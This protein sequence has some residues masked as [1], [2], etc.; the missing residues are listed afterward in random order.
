MLPMKSLIR[1]YMFFCVLMLAEAC[2][3]PTGTFV[4]LEEDDTNINFVN[5]VEESD[6]INIF[7]FENIYNGGGVGVGDFKTCISPA[8]WFPINYT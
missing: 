2:S 5:A 1:L 4:L 7:D 8:I 3:K 6:S